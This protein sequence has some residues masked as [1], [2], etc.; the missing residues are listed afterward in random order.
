MEVRW[1]VDEKRQRGDVRSNENNY[2]KNSFK[3]LFANEH[4]LN[5][6]IESTQVPL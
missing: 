6:E 3:M 5:P 2:L 1:E 4:K